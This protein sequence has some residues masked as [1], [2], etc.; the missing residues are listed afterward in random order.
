LTI[1][2]AGHETTA[3]ALTWTFYLLSQHP[4]VEAQLHAEI[5]A[6]LAGRPP[7]LDDLKYLTYTEMVIKEAMRLYPP[8][9]SV[10]RQCA[11][12][13]EVAGYPIRRKSIAVISIYA[14][15]RDERYFPNP[16]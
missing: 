15:H 13:T 12:A 16:D 6:V 2:L 4:Q 9:W 1:V 10:S 7:S 14:L 3:N 11:E 5:D 8:A